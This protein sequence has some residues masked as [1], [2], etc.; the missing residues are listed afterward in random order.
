M[1]AIS[2]APFSR[3]AGNAAPSGRRGRLLPRS[4]VSSGSGSAIIQCVA[5]GLSRFRSGLRRFKPGGRRCRSPG[6]RAAALHRQHLRREAVALAQVRRGLSACVRLRARCACGHRPLLQVLQLP[7]S[8]PRARLPNA[9]RVLPRPRE[10][11]VMCQEIYSSAAR[12]P[13][14]A[15][16][17]PGPP[18]WAVRRGLQ[19]LAFYEFFDQCAHRLACARCDFCRPRESSLV[20]LLEAKTNILRFLQEIPLTDEERSVVDGDL[21]A[22]DR[23]T[24]RLAHRPT[25]SGKTPSEIRCCPGKTCSEP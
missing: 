10:S 21:I 23:L 18:S 7:A 19:N 12:F 3:H 20:Q 17:P 22:I 4:K 11:G 15:S 1:P 24:A 14:L 9:R 16:L 8:A 5:K 6:G 2:S 13:H 25:P